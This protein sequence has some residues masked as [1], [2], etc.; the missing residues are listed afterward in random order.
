MEDVKEPTPKTIRS[1]GKSLVSILVLMEDVKEQEDWR[2]MQESFW[3]VSIL[4]LMEDV[5]E[6]RVPT[7][8]AD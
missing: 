7:R 5:K 8:M 6:R 4:V 3:Y 1:R 2:Y